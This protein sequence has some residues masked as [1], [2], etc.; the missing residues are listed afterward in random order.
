MES[1][2]ERSR[3][4]DWLAVGAGLAL[5]L[6]RAY[7]PLGVPML[8]L[9]YVSLA[10][11]ALVPSTNS[12]ARIHPAVVVGIGMVAV[13][14]A[15]RVAGT[16]VPS[17]GVAGV[18]VVLNLLAAVGEEA[19]FRKFLYDRLARWGI[20]LAIGISALTFAAIHVPAYG[21]AAFP[22]DLGAGILLGWQRWASGT[23]L[24]PAATHA[25][26]NLWVMVR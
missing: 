26:A 15:G 4:L 2:L 13:L 7:A 10:A 6:L 8:A 21:V 11:L 24:A 16:A 9:I 22:V 1:S 5:L 3:T 19:L 17:A 18:A 25:F 14:L 20:P 12:S 23:W